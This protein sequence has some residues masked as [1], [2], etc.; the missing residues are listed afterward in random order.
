MTG[1][2]ITEEKLAGF[3]MSGTSQDLAIDI[4]DLTATTTLSESINVWAINE[5]VADEWLRN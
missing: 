5:I 1:T 2:A 4:P 3:V